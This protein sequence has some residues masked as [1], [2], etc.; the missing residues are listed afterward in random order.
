MFVS[1]G[2]GR[3]LDATNGNY[4]VLFG[5]A[6]SLSLIGL[7]MMHCILP[8]TGSGRTPAGVEV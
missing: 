3:L 5:I 2:V 6:S 7:V 4:Q 1:M 8:K